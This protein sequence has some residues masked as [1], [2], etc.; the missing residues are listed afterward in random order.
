MEARPALGAAVKK[1]KKK[2]MV[3]TRST[4][5]AA[6]GAQAAAAAAAAA[7]GAAATAAA[8]A[9]AAV[10]AAPRTPHAS[11][12]EHPGILRLVTLNVNG[13]RSRIPALA[14]ALLEL[15]GDV[16]LLQETHLSDDDTSAAAANLDAA[17]ALGAQR[18]GVGHAGFVYHWGDGAH[19]NASRSSGVAILVR[20]SLADS[21]QLVVRPGSIQQAPGGRLLALEGRWRG[22]PF[23]IACVYLPTNASTEQQTFAR[24]L[25]APLA[26]AATPGGLH[27]WGG[28]WNFVADADRDRCSLPGPNTP[29]RPSQ[30]RAGG[31]TM[32]RVLLEAA[33]GFTDVFRHRHPTARSFT[34]HSASAASRLESRAGPTL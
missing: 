14:E 17:V 13:F 4:S 16:V 7:A 30:G 2:K 5:A 20:R 12:A 26:A 34:F 10:A 22:E 18:R 3:T 32:A 27:L 11:R 8:A 24:E 33:P 28:D 25:L 15:R 21:H 31:A 23:S 29:A 6:A 19:E 9:A 1:K